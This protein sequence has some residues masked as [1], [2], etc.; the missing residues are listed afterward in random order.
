MAFC[1]KIFILL[2]CIASLNID[3]GH[4]QEN[5]QFQIPASL[6]ECYNSSYFINRDNRLPS[7]ID[8]FIS[9]IEKVERS[10][11]FDQ[12]IRQFTVSLLH[13]F[14][15]DGI[16]IAD[17]SVSSLM[18][19]VLP[20]S[21]TGFQF[22]KFRVL[23]SRLIP[24]NAFRFP[25]ETLTRQERCSLHFMMSS[26]FN[27][28]IRGDESRVC[29][30]LS[31]YKAQR[32]P[33]STS[34]SENYK[35]DVEILRNIINHKKINPANYRNQNLNMRN[36]DY[37]YPWLENE[38]EVLP[39]Y[40]NNNNN[41]NQGISQCPVENGVI[42]TPW[43][44]VATGTLI[45]GIAA[46]LQPQTV[47]LK[48]LLALATRRRG[49]AGGSSATSPSRSSNQITTTV[50]VDNR[51]AATL[52]GDMA[53]VALIQAPKSSGTITVGANG[54]WN[55]TIN[56]Q[57][58]FLTQRRNLEMT[59]AEI[60]GGIDGLILA[61]NIE[62]W[63]SQTPNLKLSQLL[64][65]YY[66]LDGVM[67]S[68]IMACNRKE[69]FEVYAP[70]NVMIAQT[71]AFAQVLDREMQISYTLTPEVIAQFATTAVRALSSYIRK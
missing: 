47:Q 19:G 17:D 67:G 55:S 2:L 33:R 22:N 23:L 30:Q 25:N 63:R 51:W 29:N 54:A 35:N 20:Y 45:A 4:G 40:N 43:G 13:R 7:N 32:W 39:D 15:Q 12:D 28:R 37:D 14:R 71:G 8:S 68:G 69:N 66:S 53:E 10:E 5:A 24:G 56:S 26:S 58:Y 6:L 27:T 59:D 3:F 50:N 41:N 62:N 57:W 18:P 21:P 64:R 11:D 1:V 34:L 70:M 9:I 38:S 42:H 36:I 52:A 49:G 16:Q 31:Q 60:R 44:T 46:G 48:T 65:M 61:M